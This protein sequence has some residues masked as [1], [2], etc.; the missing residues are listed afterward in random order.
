M[1]LSRCARSARALTALAALAFA[2]LGTLSLAPIA[3]ADGG[4]VMTAHALLQG[5]ARAGSWFA[6]AIDVQN[7]GPTVTGE[8]RIAGGLDSRTRFGTPV[9]LATGSRKE[10]LLYAQPPTFGGSMTVQ[11]A[12]GTTVVA[13]AKVAVA[14]H[15]QTQLVVGIVAENPAKVVGEINLLPSSS[16][17]QA[18]LVPLTPADLPERIQA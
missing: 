17:G 11:L 8:L 12:T 9:E 3:S 14:L 10:Y 2:L 15:D 18:V 6:I 13:E 7:A 16:G 4:L 5:H 1:P